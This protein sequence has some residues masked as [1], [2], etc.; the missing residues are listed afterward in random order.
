MG[1]LSSDDFAAFYDAFSQRF[2]GPYDVVKDRL[3]VHADFLAARAVPGPVVDLGVGRGEWL[4]LARAAS[5]TAR[6]V[7]SNA[8]IVAATRERGF[9]VVQAD[10]LE[11]LAALPPATLGAVTAFHLIEHLNAAQRLAFLR[12][13]QRALAPGGWLIMEWPNAAHPR[14]AQYTF[15]L[16]PTHQS[17]LPIELA[18]FMAEF[19]GFS[20][21]ETVRLDE[22]QPVAFEAL[23]IAL[24][25]RKP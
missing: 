22:G 25:A 5:L 21:I 15:W 18:T 7:D 6:G 17:L 16:D 13:A 10:A 1:E 8:Q 2:R 11:Y 12:G 23:D 19:A 9:D 20:D 3:R 14:V 24:R 4:E